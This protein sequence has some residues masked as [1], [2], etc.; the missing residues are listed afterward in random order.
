MRQQYREVVNLL[1]EVT[2]DVFS[3]GLF[4]LKGGTAINLF[5][6][7]M[8]RLSVDLDLV[9]VDFQLDRTQALEQI[10]GAL[11]QIVIAMERRGFR[12]KLSGSGELESKVNI[13]DGTS[14][15]K[16]EINYVMR[17]T[18]YQVENTSITQAVQDEFRKRVTIPVLN[19]N[20]LYAS[21]FVA[22]MDRQHPRD[23]FDVYHFFQSENISEDMMEA[24]VCYLIG[25]PKPMHEVLFNNEKDI[26]SEYATHFVGMPRE[27]VSLEVLLDTRTRL[28]SEIRSRLEQRHKEFLLSLAAAEPDWSLINIAH[29][30]DMPA[31]RWKLQNLQKL[32]LQ[33]SKKFADQIEV[34]KSNLAAIPERESKLKQAL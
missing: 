16:V 26:A 28:F 13:S 1:L 23:L 29:L 32:K 15:V 30:K 17:G 25:H 22:A 6:Q 33:N 4:A 24:F 20:E 7:D 19:K 21:K 10:E 14:T 5:M 9:Y 12:A 2:H 27:D 11:Q 34:L 3:S 31:T 8:P 18:V